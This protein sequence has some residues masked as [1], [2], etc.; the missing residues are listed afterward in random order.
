MTT[1]TKT[2]E[3]MKIVASTEIEDTTQLEMRRISQATGK[4]L[5]FLYKE[6]IEEY[7]K[8]HRVVGG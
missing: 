3:N 5:R 2:K 7:A 6:A 4:R 8:N 1:L